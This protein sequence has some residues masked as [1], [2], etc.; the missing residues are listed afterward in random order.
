MVALEMDTKRGRLYTLTWP[1]AIF[2]YY[3]VST[4]MKK[5]F[6][7]SV[8][9]HAYINAVEFGGVPRSLGIDPHTG[10]VYWWNHGETIT[11]YDFAADT[12]M[13]LENHRLDIPILKVHE[14]GSD[15]DMNSWRNIRWCE[16]DRLFYGTTFFGENLFSYDPTT[17]DIEVIDRIAPGPNR[18]SGELS[19]GSLAFGLSSDGST[20]YYVNHLRPYTGDTAGRDTDALHL[21]TYDIRLR[22]YTDHGPI[23]L[24]DGRFPTDCQGMELGRDGDIY[25]VCVIP[26][27]DLST[28]KGMAIKEIRYKATPTE[29]LKRVYE[30]N[31]VI[32]RDP[33]AQ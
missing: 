5:T 10:N 11:C 4:G 24:D 25:L 8:P 2:I 32:I 12:V 30:V 22:R 6:G 13:T 18:K 14:R 28:E 7:P 33:L 23:R 29:Q 9:G 21:V 26:F 15:D 20:A 31:L 3:D 16:K 27:T 17:G 1:S 19:R